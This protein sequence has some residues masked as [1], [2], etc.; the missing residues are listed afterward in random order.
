MQRNRNK[1]ATEMIGHP[2]V[3]RQELILSVAAGNFE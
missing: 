2:A 3:T 1:T